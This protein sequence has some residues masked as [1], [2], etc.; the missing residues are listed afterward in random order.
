M[1]TC[2]RRSTSAHWTAGTAAS[3]SCLQGAGGQTHRRRGQAVSKG[4]IGQISKVAA[5]STRQ[6]GSRLANPAHP[7]DPHTQPTAAAPH[8]TART[9]VEAARVPHPVV[10]AAAAVEVSRVAAVKHVDAIHGVLGGV[11]VH[12]VHQHHNAQPEAGFEGGRGRGQAR[13][14]GGERAGLQPSPSYHMISRT[15]CSFACLQLLPQP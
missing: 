7:S 12:N 10:P 8:H 6:P 5:P 2:T 4:Q 9:V 13:R 14:G 15:A 11:G 3:P 1:L